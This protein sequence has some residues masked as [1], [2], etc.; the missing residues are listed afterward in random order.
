MVYIVRFITSLVEVMLLEQ[1]SASVVI[2]SILKTHL[3]IEI[4]S[5]GI[6]TAMTETEVNYFVH[7]LKSSCRR[8]GRI[9]TTCS[10][11]DDI[12][13]LSAEGGEIRRRV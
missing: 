11:R 1:L 6:R 7:I 3:L 2:I 8:D 13:L 9:C 12:Y 4:L 10:F 5:G